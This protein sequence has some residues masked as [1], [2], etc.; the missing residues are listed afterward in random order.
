M[1]WKMLS[2]GR[3]SK[4]LQMQGAQILRSEAYFPH[5]G[6]TKDEAQRR[7]WAFYEAVG[8]SALHYYT[9]KNQVS[10][11]PRKC[12]DSSNQRLKP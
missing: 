12:L 7:R 5:V 1:N 9:Y 8:I 4:K 6:M 2:D 3:Q 11:Q 10:R